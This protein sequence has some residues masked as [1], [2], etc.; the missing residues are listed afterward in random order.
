MTNKNL[1]IE[2]FFSAGNSKKFLDQ[3]DLWFCPNCISDRLTICISSN[4][5]K[6]LY[7]LY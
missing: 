7:N 1:K 2:Y 4:L 5:Y 3:N 6:N